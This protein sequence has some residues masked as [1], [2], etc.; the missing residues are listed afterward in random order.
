MAEGDANGGTG[1]GASAARL[2]ITAGPSA[3][4]ALP[5]DASPT[6][7][8]DIRRACIQLVASLYGARGRDLMVRSESAQ[9]VGQV[10]YLDPRAGMEALPPQV[11]GLLAPYRMPAA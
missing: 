3:G 4:W 9:D 1:A 7:P 11:A 2:P 5:N 6:L 10:S 8:A